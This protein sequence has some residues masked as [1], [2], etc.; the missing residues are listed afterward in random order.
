M[1]LQP[2]SNVAD[3][4]DLSYRKRLFSGGL[5][6]LLGIGVFAIAG[7]LGWSR[8]TQL[9]IPNALINARV[10]RVRA[11]SD[12]K[13]KALYAQPGTPIRAGDVLLR[14]EQSTEQQQQLLQLQGERTTLTAQL[15]AAE[16]SRLNLQQQLDRLSHT[17][18]RIAQAT[19]TVTAVGIE[20][21]QSQVEQARSQVNLARQTLNRYQQL[22]ASGAIALAIVDEKRAALTSAE[23]ALKQ[24]ESALTQ[25]QTEVEAMKNG[26]QPSIPEMNVVEQR[27]HLWQDLQTQTSLV[28]SLKA[29]LDAIN[30]RLQELQS[31]FSDRQDIAVTAPITGVLYSRNREP[32]EA[33]SRLDSMVSVLDCQDLWI[34]GVIAADQASLIDAQRP[35]HVEIAGGQSVQGEVELIQSI[36]HTLT[37]TVQNP[38]DR[39]DTVQVQAVQPS[40]SQDLI[41]QPI[42]RVTVRV[43]QLPQL[44]NAQQFCGV[45][46]AT[47][48]T[49]AKKSLK[50]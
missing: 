34:E 13:L 28:T 39:P 5:Y 20:S 32:S 17:Q 48:L 11:P 2:S 9:S 8:F 37:G 27:Q 23:A 24:A 15:Q 25:S 12:G 31:Q 1:T 16:A 18:G 26:D 7:G 50:W 42:V 14:L 45:G 19:T 49:F 33:V 44:Q 22:A 10:V 4:R 43:P 38:G 30:Q 35:V 36:S 40:I 29:Q 41:G 46:Q 3:I 47:E 21:K 6:L